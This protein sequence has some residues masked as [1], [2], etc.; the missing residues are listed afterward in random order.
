MGSDFAIYEVPG[1]ERQLNTVFDMAEHGD[2]EALSRMARKSRHFDIEAKDKYGRTA[3]MWACDKGHLEA[4]ETCLRLGA[5][6]ETSEPV[7]G[8][9][10]NN[11]FKTLGQAT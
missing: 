4:V 7:T 6:A 3:L 11:V 1:N 10:G 8:R 9:C 2:W 5:R